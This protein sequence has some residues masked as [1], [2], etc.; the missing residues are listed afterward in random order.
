MLG[1]SGGVSP[2]HL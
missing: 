1:G 2:R